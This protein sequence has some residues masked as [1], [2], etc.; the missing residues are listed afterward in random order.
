MYLLKPAVALAVLAASGTVAGGALAADLP[1]LPVPPPLPVAVEAFGGWYLRGDIGV[2]LQRS[3]EPENPVLDAAF[4]PVS[5]AFTKNEWDPSASLGLGFGYQFNNW[6][7]A[8]V[9]GEYRFRSGYDGRDVVV[10]GL[11]TFE[12]DFGGHKTEYV[13]LVN[14]YLDLGTWHGVTPF[15]GAGIGVAHVIIDGFT[16]D[17]LVR[18]AFI[19]ADRKSRTNLAWALYAGA[20]Y[21][22]SERLSFELAYRFLHMGTG[23]TGETRERFTGVSTVDGDSWRFE[24]IHSHDIKVGMRWNLQGPTRVHQGPISRSF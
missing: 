19:D 12:N 22:V 9:T 23:V 5:V 14:G 4:P 20:S 2:T 18:G 8:D 3:D 15:V 24:N 10:D 7:R 13:G 1:V 6:F 21:S 17:N 11:G 16:D